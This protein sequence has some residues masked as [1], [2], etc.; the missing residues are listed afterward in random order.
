MT[1]AL[2]ETRDKGLVPGQGLQEER[3]GDGVTCPQLEPRLLPQRRQ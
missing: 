1:T 3:D 2:L